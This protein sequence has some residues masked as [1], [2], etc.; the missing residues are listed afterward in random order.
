MPTEVQI[1][2]D[3]TVV[4]AD[5]A[6]KTI[7]AAQLADKT[8]TAAKIADTTITAAKLSTG[9]PNWDT[10]GN[11]T[12]SSF[13]TSTAS[14]GFLKADG[15]VDT[16][17]YITQAVPVGA[18][19]HF[20]ASTAPTGYLKANGAEALITAYTTLYN[21]LTTSGTTFPFGANTN[22]SGAAG[23][24]HFRLPDLRGEFVRGWADGRAV[25]TGRTFG[26]TQ[27]W[28]IENITGS[29][30]GVYGATSQAYNW[31]FHPGTNGAFSVIRTIVGQYNKYNGVYSA[32]S[33]STATFDASRVVNTSTETRPRNIALLACIKY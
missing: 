12:A 21:V 28:A 10:A 9:G 30:T 15:N 33:G 24:T 31:G 32:D 2:Q 22:G 7:T 16:N 25:D 4:A 17:T 29:L 14:T 11:L 8:I 19:F 23:S 26:S 20:A 6:D 3:G 13:K 5:I 1:Y 27:S 18:V